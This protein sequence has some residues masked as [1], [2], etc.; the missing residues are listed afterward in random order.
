MMNIDVV[1]PGFIIALQCYEAMCSLFTKEQVFT[2][3]ANGNTYDSA[4]E[5]DIQGVKLPEADG[6]SRN[7]IVGMTFK[8]QAQPFIPR[9]TTIKN[10]NDAGFDKTQI[11]IKVNGE[12]VSDHDETMT[13][14][15]E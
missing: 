14:D 13:I 5:I 12:S 10:I 7:A 8:I 2:Y 11:D 9:I 4:Y 6:S 3:N 15:H 1:T